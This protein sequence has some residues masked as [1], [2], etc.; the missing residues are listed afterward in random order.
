MN[1]ALAG[2]FISM[3]GNPV[4]N[5]IFSNEKGLANLL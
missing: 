5:Q 3:V 1:P 2:L 4:G